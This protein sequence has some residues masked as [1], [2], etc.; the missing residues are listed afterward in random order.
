[1]TTENRGLTVQSYNSSTSS[2]GNE[3]VD[4]FGLDSGGYAEDTPTNDNNGNLTYDGTQAYT[5]DAWNRMKTV[6]HAYR[7]TGGVH[8]GQTLDTMTYDA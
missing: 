4:T 5:Y 7:D 1:M 3:L 2:W 8:S 6:A